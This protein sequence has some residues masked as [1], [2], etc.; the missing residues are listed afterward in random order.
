MKYAGYI[1][2]LVILILIMIGYLVY[3]FTIR[4]NSKDFKT[5]RYE[6]YGYYI[7]IKKRGPY[8]RNMFKVRQLIDKEIDKSKHDYQILARTAFGVTQA[9]VVDLGPRENTVLTGKYVVANKRNK[10]YYYEIHLTEELAEEARKT[11]IR[12]HMEDNIIDN[13]SGMSQKTANALLNWLA[14]ER[15]DD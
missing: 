2:G 10:S 12:W 15:I 7:L 11:I 9:K 4:D 1:F 3:V 5:D 13:S 8:V 14:G 6:D